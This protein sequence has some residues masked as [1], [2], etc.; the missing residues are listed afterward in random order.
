MYV[1]A[2][3]PNLLTYP[4]HYHLLTTHTVTVVARKHDGAP[5]LAA[6]ALLRLHCGPS[7]ALL[8]ENVIRRLCLLQQAN[9]QYRKRSWPALLSAALRLFDSLVT[10]KRHKVAILVAA[11]LSSTAPRLLNNFYILAHFFDIFL[12]SS[13]FYNMLIVLV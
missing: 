1:F 9:L 3:F 12:P 6:T 10:L 2:T 7:I 13:L 11:D 4:I 8:H 5:V